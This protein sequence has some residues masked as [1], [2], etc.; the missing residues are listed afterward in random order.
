MLLFLLP[1]LIGVICFYLIPYVQMIYYSVINNLIQKNF[2]GLNNYASLLGNR[3]FK[4]A[5]ANM[6]ILSITGVC[7][8]VPLSL[9]FALLLSNDKKI[10]KLVR[11]INLLPLFVPAACVIMI[12]RIMFDKQ[13]AVNQLL[14]MLGINNVDWL[15]TGWGR[16]A[17]LLMFLWKNTGLNTIVF[18]GALASVPKEQIE[19]AK[20]EGAGK[21]QIFW[22]VKLRNIMPSIM[23]TA[24]IALINSY[25]LFRE[26]YLLTGDYPQEELY[27]LSHFLNN[28]LR[29]IEYGK[30]SAASIL[31]ALATALIMAVMFWTDKKREEQE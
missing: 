30:L 3:S 28:M 10:F 26:V 27:L 11:S 25:K 2:I 8:V 14:Q 17:V 23:F 1:S 21:R 7:T 24:V 19:V 22:L 15:K 12:W 20:L 4:I 31:Y 16:I 9:S 5:F 18:M 6:A 13:G 29:K